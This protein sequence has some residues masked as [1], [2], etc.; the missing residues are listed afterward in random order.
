[1][2]VVR[3]IQRRNTTVTVEAHAEILFMPG[4]S[5]NTWANRFTGRIRS[6]T[7][8]E[9]PANKRPRWAHYGKPLKSTI[10]SA[11]PRF[12]GNGGDKQR[13]YAAV[14]SSA[15][16]ALYVDQ[17]TGVF[18][19]NGPYEAKILPPWTR[20]GGSLYERT[21]RP[22]GPGTKRVAPVMIQGQPGQHYFDKGL[23]AAFRSMRMRSAQLPGEGGP[24]IT[25]ALGTMPDSLLNSIGNT[26]VNP[27]FIGQLNEWR[28]WRDE[29]W[30]NGGRLGEGRTETPSAPRAPTRA[31][32]PPRTPRPPKPPTAVQIKARYFHAIKKERQDLVAQATAKYDGKNVHVSGRRKHNGVYAYEVTLTRGDG[33]KVSFWVTSDYQAAL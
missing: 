7:I 29:A 30:A 11:R 24:R 14:G 18:G 3:R 16:Y 4:G 21:W 12:W 31:P 10:V 28:A 20:G 32:K 23:A 26:P 22:G 19:G 1:M 17:G 25:D 2:G 8:Q 9:A 5:V 15:P 27:A 6:K 33:R 13:V